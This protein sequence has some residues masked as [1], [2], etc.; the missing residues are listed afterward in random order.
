MPGVVL[1]DKRLSPVWLR[2]VEVEVAY[3]FFKLW[4]SRGCYGAK[5]ARHKVERETLGNGRCPV[6]LAS[7]DAFFEHLDRLL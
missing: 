2:L 5:A 1:P 3:G 4:R 6:F 7:S